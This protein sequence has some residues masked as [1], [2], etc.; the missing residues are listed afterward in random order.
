MKR[1]LDYISGSDLRDYR[2]GQYVDYCEELCG[3][4]AE[5]D[6]I[7]ARKDIGWFKDWCFNRDII[8]Q[9]ISMFLECFVM[10]EDVE[11]DPEDREYHDKCIKLCYQNM[12][13]YMPRYDLKDIEM[14]VDSPTPHFDYPKEGARPAE[15]S[16]PKTKRKAAGK[17]NPGKE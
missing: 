7:C 17:Q 6:E 5:R 13:Y 3:F 4:M 2:P 15:E 9:R 11:I 14:T 10:P 8:L 1:F 12:R 16:K